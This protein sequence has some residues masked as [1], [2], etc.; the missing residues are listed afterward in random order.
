MNP[1]DPW[2]PWDP[3]DESGETKSETKIEKKNNQEGERA[4]G[5]PPA[6][7][8]RLDKAGTVAKL[9]AML[10]GSGQEC[11]AFL[12]GKCRHVRADKTC[13]FRHQEGTD[14][15]RIHCTCAHNPQGHMCSNGKTCLYLH[16][17]QED[18]DF[19]PEKECALTPHRVRPCRRG[20]KRRKRGRYPCYQKSAQQ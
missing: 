1:R 11:Q 8:Q 10:K 13:P 19:K 7:K 9:A 20:C 18:Y 6:K 3:R 12:A 5:P 2:D 4:L 16:Q 14:P 15:F 17:N